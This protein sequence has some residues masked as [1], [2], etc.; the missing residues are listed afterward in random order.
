M[1]ASFDRPFARAVLVFDC[2]QGHS[3]LP[4]V[5]MAHFGIT[6]DLPG[7]VDTSCW[8]LPHALAQVGPKAALIVFGSG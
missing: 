5:P 1:V 3:G 6:I 8:R 7:D 2:G 4:Q